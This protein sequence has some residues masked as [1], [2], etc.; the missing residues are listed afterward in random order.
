MFLWTQFQFICF[1]VHSF[2]ISDNHH[3]EKIGNTPP[4][5]IDDETSKFDLP[6]G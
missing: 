5:C 6:K 3:Y 2:I 4:V 1:K